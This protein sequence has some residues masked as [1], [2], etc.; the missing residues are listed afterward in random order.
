MTM[1]YVFI[2]SDFN[3]CFSVKLHTF[4]DKVLHFYYF[5]LMV[6]YWDIASLP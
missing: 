4:A 6:L 3:H 2:Y 1:A 5:G